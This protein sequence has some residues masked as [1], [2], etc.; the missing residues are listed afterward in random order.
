MFS[1]EPGSTSDSGDQPK[2]PLAPGVGGYSTG[3]PADQSRPEDYLNTFPEKEYLPNSVAIGAIAAVALIILVAIGASIY[4]NRTQNAI[5]STTYDHWSTQDGSLTFDYPHGWTVTPIG[6]PANSNSLLGIVFSSG[7][8]RIEWHLDVV[9]TLVIGEAMRGMAAADVTEDIRD[10]GPSRY[11]FNRHSRDRM[12]WITSYNEL[13]PPPDTRAMTPKEKQASQW[14]MGEVISEWTGRTGFLGISKPVHGYR[15][16]WSFF[17]SCYVGM[18]ECPEDQWAQLAPIMKHV[19][20]TID[21]QSGSDNNGGSAQSGESQGSDSSGSQPNSDNN[22]TQSSSSPQFQQQ[23]TGPNTVTP[24]P[25]Y[26]QPQ[27]SV[28][29]PNQQ[30][31]NGYQPPSTAPPPPQAPSQPAPDQTQQQPPAQPA[32]APPSPSGQSTTPDQSTTAPQQGQPAQQS[33][34]PAGSQ[35]GQQQGQPAPSQ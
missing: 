11:A 20:T 23:Q 5:V 10:L 15:M 19:I 4:A 17:T 35:T 25:A 29:T 16:A 12:G 27:Y 13:P 28:P 26:A 24:P 8:A 1:A 33:P 32:Q 21:I 6:S 2:P 14:L 31:Q 34:P 30:Q 22:T 3:S 18:C 7:D 9:D